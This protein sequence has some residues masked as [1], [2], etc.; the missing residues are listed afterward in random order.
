M[1]CS[2]MR[3]R[4][5]QAEVKQRKQ[6]RK[7][8]ENRKTALILKSETERERVL[9]IENTPHRTP[10]RSHQAAQ[11]QRQLEEALYRIIPKHRRSQNYGIRKRSSLN[12]LVRGRFKMKKL[13]SDGRIL[14]Y[15]V[16][17][18][19]RWDDNGYVHVVTTGSILMIVSSLPF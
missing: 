4:G 3:R 12:F 17:T 2:A 1:Q 18:R 10:H 15:T 11:I 16:S 6:K 5:R 9:E 8:K 7:E 14:C 13:S 19:G